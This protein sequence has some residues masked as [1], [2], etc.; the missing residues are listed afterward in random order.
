MVIYSQPHDLVASWILSSYVLIYVHTHI[1]IT[2][3]A[4][5]LGTVELSKNFG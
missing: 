4:K 5:Q 3:A 1:Y 2:L